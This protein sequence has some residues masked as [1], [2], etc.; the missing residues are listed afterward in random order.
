[1]TMT[2]GRIVPEVYPF[3]YTLRGPE[4]DFPGQGDCD[5]S[6]S[7]GKRIFGPAVLECKAA[8]HDLASRAVDRG[9]AACRQRGTVLSSQR[10]HPGEDARALV[11]AQRGQAPGRGQDRGCKPGHR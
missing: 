4:C 1:M 11:T 3:V 10:T 5:R 2:R 7:L 6:M 9:A 8:H